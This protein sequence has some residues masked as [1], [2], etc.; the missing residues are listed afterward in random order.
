[1]FGHDFVKAACVAGSTNMELSNKKPSSLEFA[2]QIRQL[3]A[4]GSKLRSSMTNF[5][6]FGLDFADIQLPVAPS[7]NRNQYPSSPSLA[8]LADISQEQKT[9]S[10][11]RSQLDIKM[12]ETEEMTKNLL[13]NRQ[14]TLHDPL[15]VRI[16]APSADTRLYQQNTG[17]PASVSESQLKETKDE[18][19][20]LR[21]RLQEALN[22]SEEQK[23]QFRKNIEELKSQLQEAIIG[24]DHVLEMKKRE[25][26]NQDAVISRLQSS[27]E[28]LEKTNCVQEKTLLDVNDKLEKL[29]SEHFSMESAFNQIKCMLGERE[30]LRNKAFYEGE[31]PAKQS[32]SVIVH[33]LERC[34]HDFDIKMEKFNEQ[35]KELDST[36]E[37]L[38]IQISAKQKQILEENQEK[39]K[40]ESKFNLQEERIQDLEGMLKQCKEDHKEDKESWK[41]KQESLQESLD[42]VQRDLN[43]AISERNEAIQKEAATESKFSDIQDTIKRLEMDL[44][45]EKEQNKKISNQDVDVQRRE[46][47]LRS[48]LQ[49]RE[50]EIERL[51]GNIDSTKQECQLLLH[52]K[53]SELEKVQQKKHSD[54]TVALTEQLATVTDKY[55]KVQLDYELTKQEL[56]NTIE[57]HSAILQAQEEYK[58]Q[59]D[60][61]IE[62]KNQ[63][64]TLLEERCVD[65]ER[66]SQERDYYFKVLEDRKKEV[67]ELENQLERTTIQL[68]EREKHFAVLQ[69]QNDN[70]A[71]MVEISNKSNG[72]IKAENKLLQS[73]IANKASE[74]EEIKQAKENIIKKLKIRESRLKDVEVELERLKSQVKDKEIEL[75]EMSKQKETLFKELR[76]SR[77]EV[78]TLTDD[79]DKFKV[80]LEEK[81]AELGKVISKMG[82]KLKVAEHDLKLARKVLRTHETVDGNA[83]K[84]AGKM[85][86]EVTQKRSQI[87]FLQSQVSWLEE[88]LET[89]VR[90][91]KEIEKENVNIASKLKATSSRTSELNTEIGNLHK[92]LRNLKDENTKLQAALEKAAV[93][94]A[95]AQA[96][97]EQHEQDI[98]RLKLK[99]Q[100]QIK[101]LQRTGQIKACQTKTQLS[102]ADINEHSPTKESAGNGVGLGMIGEELKELLGDMRTLVHENRQRKTSSS[103]NARKTDIVDTEEDLDTEPDYLPPSSKCSK[104]SK[105]SSKKKRRTSGDRYKPR[106][107]QKSPISE[108]L[109]RQRSNSLESVEAALNDNELDRI[110]PHGCSKPDHVPL[111]RETEDLCKRLERKMDTLS[112]MGNI[113]NEKQITME[114]LREHEKRLEKVKQNGGTS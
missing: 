2:E 68:E 24:R 30:R 41:Q 16:V 1:M 101:E 114:L 43:I 20:R 111:Y 73:E 53:V 64:A 110:Q 39:T 104:G 105:D 23:Q 15:Q 12:K 62:K 3:E 5:N 100:L 36:A 88:C 10:D 82:A 11:L 89:A 65:I 96:N 91:K 25:A 6:D 66:L 50:R 108:L 67:V 78:S 44:D 34:F 97:I 17:L 113:Q 76:E 109:T 60:V 22:I 7:S 19:L 98:V 106:S 52:Q 31:P 85:Q 28:Q 51:Q 38:K 13:E 72:D 69:Q 21:Q 93:K 112:Q 33:T 32:P 47:A 14:H 46:D 84:V 70:I 40:F 8:A 42:G 92:K 59:L 95:S 4:E 81:E 63:L 29:Q 71:N 57:K 49:D 102:K 48:R 55:H 18:V 56:R 26:V 83:I 107:G 86:K 37:A 94:Y 77:Y 75:D 74:V 54:Q 87:D 45:I 58:R 61:S 27:C 90:E 103:S 80:S 99:H 79:R 35:C 9:L